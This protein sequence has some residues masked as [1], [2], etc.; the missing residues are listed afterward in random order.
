MRT[1][2]LLFAFLLAFLHTNLLAQTQVVMTPRISPRASIS[3]DIGVTQVTIEYSRP[4]VRGRNIWGTI[5]PFGMSNPGWGTAT[6]APWRAGADENTV[7]TFST[8]V[9][10]NGISIE[11]GSYGLF[12]VIQETGDVQIILC[13]NKDSWG[14]YFYDEEEIVARARTSWQEHTFSEYLEYAFD[15]FT[16]NSAYCALNWETKS[17]PFEIVV[18]LNATVVE[19]LRNDLRGTARFSYIGPMEAANWCVQNNTNLEEALEWANLASNMNA[20]FSTLRV[21]ADALRALGKMEESKAVM[22]Q[23]LPMASVLQLHGYGRQLITQGRVDDALNVFHANAKQNP[24]TWPVNYG[25]A[26]GYSAKG[27]YTKAIG[28][29]KKA[30]KICPDDINRNIIRENL[31]KLERGEDIN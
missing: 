22:N 14:S 17:I 28:Y 11:A 16:K 20:Q 2:T 1:L 29:L 19:Q 13:S 10:L 7:I 4:A 25:L 24:N 27:Q 21:K 30:E 6:S 5:V 18:D 8:P 15:D 31:A 12:M 3:Q 23:A 26:R 9:K